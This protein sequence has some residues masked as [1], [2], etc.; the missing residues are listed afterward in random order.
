MNIELNLEDLDPE[1]A[2][3]LAASMHNGEAVELLLDGVPVG[4]VTALSSAEI[5][6]STASDARTH[7]M[8]ALRK[9]QHVCLTHNRVRVGYVVPL[10]DYYKMT[11][12]L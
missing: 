7:I 11:G 2:R 8:P 4:R 10:E 6:F 9:K 1:I 5:V 12:R 3:G